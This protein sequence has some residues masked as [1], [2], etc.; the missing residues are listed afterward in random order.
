MHVMRILVTGSS[1][2]LG[3]ALMRVLRAGGDEVV[4]LDVLEGAYTDVVGSIVD[5]ALV[6]RCLDGVD[7]VL[8][9]ATLHKPHVGSHGRQEFVDT[10]VTGTLNLLEEAVAAGAGRFVFTST[11]SAFGRALT[12][13]EGRPAAWITEDV[14]PV[15]RNVYGVTKTSAEGLCELVARDHGLPCVILRTSRFFPEGDDRDEIRT[16]Y[17][18]ANL[19]TNELLYRRV[20]LEDVVGAHRRALDRAPAL[21][22]GRYIVS[23]TTPFTRADVAELRTDAPAVVGR[24]FPDYAELYDRLGWRMF[25]SIERVYDNALARADL[26]WVPRHDFRHALDRL[27]RGEDPRSDLAVAV[28]AKGYH[29]V[30]TGPYTVR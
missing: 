3:E 19:K 10:N 17:A 12:P 6:R 18:D 1:G 4:G 20:D 14:T 27:E 7:A 26:G 25:G 9:T 29:P 5:R 11:T 2:H 24:L 13:G 15:P 28:G 8:H 16:A 21:G 23:A 22:F 30:S